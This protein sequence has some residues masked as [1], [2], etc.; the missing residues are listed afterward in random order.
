MR[1]Q[2]RVML[3]IWILW[4][5]GLITDPIRQMWIPEQSFATYELCQNVESAFRTSLQQESSTSSIPVKFV[6]MPD[7]FIPPQQE[8]AH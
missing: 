8:P 5:V 4:R 7:T 6:C 1:R 2:Y 3:G